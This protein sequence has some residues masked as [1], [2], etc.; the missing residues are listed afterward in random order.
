MIPPAAV[1]SELI[2]DRTFRMQRF[3]ATIFCLTLTLR[4]T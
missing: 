2:Y 1:G 4:Q 3:S